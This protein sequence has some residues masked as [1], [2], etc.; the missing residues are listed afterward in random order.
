MPEPGRRSGLLQSRLRLLEPSADAKMNQARSV[1]NG[2]GGVR[3]TVSRIII[4]V[5]TGLKKPPPRRRKT[6]VRTKALL[7][8]LAGITFAASLAL[9]AAWQFEIRK[10]DHSA[11]LKAPGAVSWSTLARVTY[12]RFNDKTNLQFDDGI[13]ALGGKWTKLRGFVTPLASAL[14]QRHFILSSKPPAC[15]YCLP[16]GPEEMV[17]IFCRRPVNYSLDPITVSGRF[18]ILHDEASGFYYRMTD[19]EPVSQDS[20][21]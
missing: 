13:N 17:E 3:G 15:P 7:P 1:R 5:R 9:F 14:D 10:P 21:L 20:R 19:A 12:V 4:N 2:G 6:T 18:E 11:M 16:A 8:Y